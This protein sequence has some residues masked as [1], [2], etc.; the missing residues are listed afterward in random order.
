MCRA[1]NNDNKCREAR[2]SFS[3]TVS[4][5]WAVAVTE[6]G[7]GRHRKL[8]VHDTGTAGRPKDRQGNWKDEHATGIKELSMTQTR[9][10][11]EA[12]LTECLTPFL[13]C[14][15]VNRRRCRTIPYVI[16]SAIPAVV[17][18]YT[19]EPN[20]ALVPDVH[21]RESNKSIKKWVKR[22]GEKENEL[23]IRCHNIPMYIF[24]LYLCN[25]SIKAICS[26]CSHIE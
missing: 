2:A 22:G 21:L 4:I 1:D 15:L 17:L 10:I 19:I 6:I 11:W 25:Y 24:S 8:S 3:M 12:W 5:F 14:T 20:M 23:L 13:L 16:Q 26:H 18:Y 9:G 7:A